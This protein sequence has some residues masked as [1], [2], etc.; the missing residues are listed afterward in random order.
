MV[1]V[2]LTAFASHPSLSIF[3]ELPVRNPAYSNNL[4]ACACIYYDLLTGVIFLPDPSNEA[5]REIRE[6][7]YRPLPGTSFQDLYNSEFIGYSVYNC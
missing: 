3:S 2:A 5:Y 1:V 7:L 4:Y 6:H